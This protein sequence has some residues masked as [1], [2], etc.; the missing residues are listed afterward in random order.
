MIY[1]DNGAST[2]KK[3][4]KVIK[5]VIKTIK[6]YSV[7]PGRSGHDLS[8][9]TAIKVYRTRELLKQYFN[10]PDTSHA[11]F[12]GSCTE[13]LN[14]ALQGTAQPN[15]HILTTVYEHNSV[16]R[17]L[18]HLKETKNI[19][20]TVVKPSNHGYITDKELTPHLTDKTYMLVVNHT[21]N[22][23]G[24]TQ[25]LYNLGKFAKKHKLLFVVDS[26]QS[27]GHEKID[28]KQ[29]NIDMLAIAGHKGLLAL[30]GI[31]ALITT[32]DNITPIK[33][34][35]T[36]TN[37]KDITQ[38]TNLPE[39]LESGTL[40]T[41]NIL[42][43]YEGIKYIQK[44]EDRINSKIFYLS[45]YL[46]TLMKQL[47]NYKLLSLPNKSGV[48]SLTHKQLDNNFIATQLNKK[49]RIAV[50]SGLQCAPLIHKYQQ[51]LTTGTIR[52][53]IG[54]NNS[55]KDIKKVFKALKAIDNNYKK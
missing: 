35:G 24:I 29:H 2:Y 10:A 21:S 7:N 45:D 12:T 14:L 17:V 49:Y 15:G 31:G 53:S 4:R 38:P 26:A 46:V 30:Q 43:L 41:P 9:I 34:G 25:N 37:S 18:Q 23:T 8:S 11:I 52:I 44:H 28:I 27:A 42:S 55:R 3:P 22:V 54:H 47:P 51:T 16:L 5:T 33:F 36:G 32:V 20:Y 48:I 1:L 50:R 6:R 13:S 40:A 39:S 19:D